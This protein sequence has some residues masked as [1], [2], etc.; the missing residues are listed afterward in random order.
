MIKTFTEEQLRAL[1]EELGFELEDALADTLL[2]PPPALPATPTAAQRLAESI[3]RCAAAAHDEFYAIGP[4]T[5]DMA[6]KYESE[7]SKKSWREV[8]LAVLR[9]AGDDQ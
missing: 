6:F 2:P 3:E 7:L 8:A 5:S 1:R 9:A 4:G